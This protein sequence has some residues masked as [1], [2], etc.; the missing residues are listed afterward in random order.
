MIKILFVC[1]GNICR[2]PMAEA[3]FRKLIEDNGLKGEFLIDSAGIGDWHIGNPPHEGTLHILDHNNVN[4][5]GLR[6]RQVQNRDL[7]EF[8][9][10]I[11]MD[12]ENVGQLRSMA[13]YKKSARI[14]RLL[15]YVP[16]LELDDV[17]DPYFTGNF[18]EVYD[19]VLAGC[20]YL[21]DDIRKE[22]H[23]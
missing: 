23:I 11:A 9:Y 6:A 18:E 19:L 22:Q 16:G 3:V 14:A 15:D 12:V 8:D 21:L 4:Y 13:G 10:I 20:Q 17:P 7:E 1:L 2:S 5:D